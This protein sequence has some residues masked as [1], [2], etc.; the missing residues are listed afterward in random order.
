MFAGNMY[1]SRVRLVERLIAKGIPLRLYGGGFPRWVGE[2]SARVAHPGRYVAR[3]EKAR[4]FRSA[5]DVLNTMHSAEVSGVNA[6]LLEAAGCG[7]AVLTMS[8]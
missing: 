3:E 2:T 7:A 1:P 6:R 5:A 8:V 4:I